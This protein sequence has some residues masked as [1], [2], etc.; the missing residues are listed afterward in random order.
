MIV[1]LTFNAVCLNIS[2]SFT[3]RECAQIRLNRHNTGR[4]QLVYEKH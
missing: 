4:F 1:D 3:A 2:Y